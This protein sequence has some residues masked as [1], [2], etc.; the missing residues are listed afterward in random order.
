MDS[1]ERISTKKERAIMAERDRNASRRELEA[2]LLDKAWKDPA[3]RRAL[4]EDPRG[5]IERELQVELPAGVGLTVLEETPTQRYLVLPPAGSGEGG[6]L[7]DAELEAVAGGDPPSGQTVP[8]YCEGQSCYT[9]Y[10]HL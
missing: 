1:F 10:C 3:F 8:T 6:A 4:L 2:R 7:S 9:A 5:A